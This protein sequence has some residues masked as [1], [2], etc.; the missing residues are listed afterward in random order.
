MVK[1][2]AEEPRAR[3]VSSAKIGVKLGKKG[4]ERIDIVCPS[5][6]T[7]CLET[8]EE[9]EGEARKA[10]L[11]AGGKEFNYIPCLNAQDYWLDLFSDFL[12]KHL[13]G[14]EEQF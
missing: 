4:T 10:F 8:H 13:N 1:F 2:F 11:D 9:I 14:W 7:D 3:L 6:I 5:F 12:G